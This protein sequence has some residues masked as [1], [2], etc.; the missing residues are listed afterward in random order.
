VLVPLMATRPG[1]RAI[2]VASR[3]T[4]PDCG[5]PNGQVR[6]VGHILDDFVLNCRRPQAWIWSAA[7]TVINGIWRKRS[8]RTSD[9]ASVERIE[10][11]LLDVAR[12]G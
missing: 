4:L 8:Q 9:I 1:G 7:V 2:D 6:V 5:K 3:D 11:S 12:R 10:I